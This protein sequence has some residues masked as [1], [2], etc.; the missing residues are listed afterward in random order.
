[1]SDFIDDALATDTE[2][3]TLTKEEV[4]Q[5]I[6]DVCE[7]IKTAEPTRFHPLPTPPRPPLGKS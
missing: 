3:R 2:W 1:M 5:S 4:A 6:L 7:M